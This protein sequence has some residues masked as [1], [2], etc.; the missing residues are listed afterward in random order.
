MTEPPPRP[1]RVM[2]PRI[3]PAIHVSH[4]RVLSKLSMMALAV[5]LGLSER[6]RHTDEQ[7]TALKMKGVDEKLSQFDTKLEAE[8][9]VISASLREAHAMFDNTK[10]RANDII[11]SFERTRTW[12]TWIAGLILG[13]ITLG[14]LGGGSVIYYYAESIKEKSDL[15]DSYIAEM[16]ITKT[17]VDTLRG[18]IARTELLRALKMERPFDAADFYKELRDIQATNEAEIGLDLIVLRSR[19]EGKIM[20]EAEMGM[21]EPIDYS[22]LLSYVLA[23]VPT[24]QEKIICYSLLLVNA[25]SMNKDQDGTVLSYGPKFEEILFE[26]GAYV[27]EHENQL[28]QV[29]EEDLPAWE[30]LFAKKP[31]NQKSLERVK[32]LIPIK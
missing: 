13:I 11:D 32:K 15:A 10:L 9:K 21:E 30:D 2:I 22:L 7:I 16:E 6:L 29:K 14:G 25:I 8:L 4:V 5:L 31:E 3:S 27:K 28:I 19:I 26:L 23:D 1:P 20:E 12:L 18:K 17:K 24:P